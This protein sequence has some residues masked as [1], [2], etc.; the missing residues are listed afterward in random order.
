MND[1]KISLTHFTDFVTS[2][3]SGRV[4][5]VRDAIRLRDSIDANRRS[6]DGKG[7]NPDFYKPMKLYLSKAVQGAPLETIESLLFADPRKQAAFRLCADGFHKFLAQQKVTWRGPGRKWEWSS[8]QLTVSVNPEIAL[9]ID[10][11]NWLLKL[12]FKERNLT[13]LPHR[14]KAD[15]ILHLLT[16]GS[17][18]DETV[19]V[20]DLRRGAI[21]ALGKPV[22]D[23]ELLLRGEAV[24][25]LEI[26]KGLKAAAA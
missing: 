8:G 5:A 15:L 17:E 9:R 18:E 7:F 19:G 12:Y 3:P 25:Y 23:C 22:R 16:A 14:T 1:L 2:T 4:Q 20:L 11:N 26:W 13:K 24:S 21:L 6:F 10:G